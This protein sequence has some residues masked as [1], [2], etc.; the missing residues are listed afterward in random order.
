M[1]F[2]FQTNSRFPQKKLF[3]LNTNVYQNVFNNVKIIVYSAIWFEN[4]QTYE[5]LQGRVSYRMREPGNVS[6]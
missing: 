5:P 1:E 3:F 6:P 4:Y 2:V